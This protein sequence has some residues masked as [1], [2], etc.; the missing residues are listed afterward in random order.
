MKILQI[1]AALII[2]SFAGCGILVIA[3]VS[4]YGISNFWVKNAV[5]LVF[6]VLSIV[7]FY[8]VFIAVRRRGVISFISAVHASTEA[9]DLYD[10]QDEVLTLSEFLQLDNATELIKG[11]IHIWGDF[12]GRSL[13]KMSTAI[14]IEGDQNNL[15]LTFNDNNQC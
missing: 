8:N 12:R 10:S 15:T 9:D 7:I 1:L 5:T 6:L 4:Y 2:A 11:R 3:L 14:E 13:D